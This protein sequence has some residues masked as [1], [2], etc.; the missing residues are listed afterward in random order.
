MLVANHLVLLPD[1][2]TLT[3]TLW[4]NPWR[5]SHINTGMNQSTFFFF[6][7]ENTP[8]RPRYLSHRLLWDIGS[9]NIEKTLTVEFSEL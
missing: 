8:S 3:G 7:G 5:V 4:L 9:D 1:R 2:I 6:F